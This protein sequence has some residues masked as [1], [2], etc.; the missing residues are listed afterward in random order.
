MPAPSPESDPGSRLTHELGSAAYDGGDMHL[1]TNYA[2]EINTI[3]DGQ[4]AELEILHTLDP[5]Q[6]SG[7]SVKRR[8]GLGFWIASS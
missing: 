8:L 6:V 7:Q 1:G 2:G 4:V 5:D 3:A